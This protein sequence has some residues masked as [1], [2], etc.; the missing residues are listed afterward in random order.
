[1]A[2]TNKLITKIQTK[3]QL[4]QIATEM[5]LNHTDKVTKIDTTSV[6]NGFLF[7]ISKMGQKA[8]KEVA[9]N[10]SRYFPELSS[11]TYL[12]DSS[13]LFGVSDRLSAASSSSFVKIIATAGTQYLSGINKFVSKN[14]IEFDLLES[15]TIDVNGVGYGKLRSIQSGVGSNV[16]AGTIITVTPLPSGHTAC[17]NEFKAVGGRDIESDESFKIR[18]KNH[19]NLVSKQN[20]DYL[21]EIIREIDANILKAFNLGVNS[22]G[23]I[24]IGLLRENGTTITAEEIKKIENYIKDY[25]SFIDVDTQGNLIGLSLIN[26]SYVYINFDFRVDISSN[27]NVE[28]VRQNMQTQIAKYLDFRYWEEGV[29]VEW[30]D[31][32]QIV[33]NIDGVD[34]V[35][36]TNFAPSTDTLVGK[37]ELPR[38]RGFIMRDLDDIILFNNSSNTLEVFYQ[39]VN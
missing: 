10:E 15:I 17:T 22:E 3:D 20:L 37:G 32:L 35:P 25:L 21:V 28:T 33:K 8:I 12:D 29:K 39:F 30:D 34:Y 2:A 18:I 27:Y 6:M 7:A 9:I 24:E 38:A 13:D 31:L 14:G 26:V 16:D 1:M 19:P 36:D 5:F 11:G 23:K 4:K